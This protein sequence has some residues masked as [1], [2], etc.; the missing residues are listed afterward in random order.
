MVRVLAREK[1]QREEVFSMHLRR[2]HLHRHLPYQTTPHPP[3]HPQ[4]CT[5][6]TRARP[7]TSIH[8][9]T[10]TY[11]HTVTYE[12]VYARQAVEQMLPSKMA[13][14]VWVCGCLGGDGW[15]THLIPACTAFR[16]VNSPAEAPHEYACSYATHNVSPR[17]NTYR[18]TKTGV[19]PVLGRWWGRERRGGRT[20]ATHVGGAGR[21]ERPG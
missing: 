15:Y 2:Q 16:Q 5:T 21:F 6:Y 1:K 9:C 11:T 3:V 8:R 7:T 20:K 18:A 10:D 17:P 14:V 13:R 4:F 12:H 19:P